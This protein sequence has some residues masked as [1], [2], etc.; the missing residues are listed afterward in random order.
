MF[1]D[2]REVLADIGEQA[3]VERRHR[4][5]MQGVARQGVDLRRAAPVEAEP[6]ADPIV[7]PAGLRLNVVARLAARLAD[8][9][10]VEIVEYG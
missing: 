7:E 4:R 8:C 5:E 1:R 2:Q 6:G 10:A 9:R 3:Q